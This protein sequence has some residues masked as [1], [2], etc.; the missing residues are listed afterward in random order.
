VYAGAVCLAARAPSTRWGGGTAAITLAKPTS[1][2]RNNIVTKLLTTMKTMRGEKEKTMPR[3]L[4]TYAI[5]CNTRM[6]QQQLPFIAICRKPLV[7]QVHDLPISSLG[8]SN[9]ID[10]R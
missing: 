1:R 4:D 9:A 5:L 8:S 6:T 7:V 2:L 10:S 3:N